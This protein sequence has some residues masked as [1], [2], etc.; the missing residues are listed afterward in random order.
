M[1]DILFADF[2][3]NMDQI[4]HVEGLSYMKGGSDQLDMR[5]DKELSSGFSARDVLS[6]NLTYLD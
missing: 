6:K 1:A 4:E 2:G 5:Y 3:Y